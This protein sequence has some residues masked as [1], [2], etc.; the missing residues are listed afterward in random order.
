MTETRA[1]PSFPR[2]PLL[3]AAA[4]IGLSIAVAAIGRLTGAAIPP[5]DGAAVVARDLRFADQ[6][7]GGVAVIDADRDR[8]ITTLAP[9]T[10]GFVRA[11]VRGLV[12]E[13]KREGQGPEKPFRLTA[14]QDDRLTLDDPATGRRVEL[15]AFGHTNE[16]AFAQ[17]L[18]IQ[19]ATP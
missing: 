12:S 14:W 2:A 10:N 3:G 4:V 7:D 18:T 19:P 8:R 13:R 1:T 9:T 16:A 11:T 17:L 15:E 6:I 5:P